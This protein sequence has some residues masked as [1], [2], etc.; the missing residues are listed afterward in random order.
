MN[1]WRSKIPGSPRWGARRPVSPSAVPRSRTTYHWPTPSPCFST[2]LQGVVLVLD[3]RAVEHHQD[4]EESLIGPHADE[5]V[6]L[7]RPLADVLDGFV[8]QPKAAGA[9]CER[10]W[11]PSS[12]TLAES[13]REAGGSQRLP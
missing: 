13:T 11:R 10:L 12:R 4:D 6:L 8:D 5:R 3:V 1:G 7:P 9:P 2:S